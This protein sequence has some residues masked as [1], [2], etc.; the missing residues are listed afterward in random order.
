[1]PVDPRCPICQGHNVGKVAT[2]QFYCWDCFIE[3]S[4][5]ARGVRLYRVEPDGELSRIEGGSTPYADEE[6]V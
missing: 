6:W 5:G 3:F 2:G 4:V 1:M